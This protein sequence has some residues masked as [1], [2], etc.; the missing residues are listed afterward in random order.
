MYNN[1]GMKLEIIPLE[2]EVLIKIDFT[3]PFFIE[4]L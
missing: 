4:I 1:P 2:K 3:H